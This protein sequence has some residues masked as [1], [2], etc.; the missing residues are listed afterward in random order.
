[1]TVL[2][3]IL[4]STVKHLKWHRH[5]RIKTMTDQKI[6]DNAPEGAIIFSDVESVYIKWLKPQTGI[7]ENHEG[8]YGILYW[9]EKFKEWDNVGA[10]YAAKLLCSS[11]S[12]ADIKE[13]VELRKANAEVEKERDVLTAFIIKRMPPIKAM[14]S[15]YE[16]C[17]IIADEVDSILEAHNLEQQVKGV[18][19]YADN[20]KVLPWLAVDGVDARTAIVLA[21]LSAKALKEGKQ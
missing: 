13:L 21:Q 19:A 11:R 5:M 8:K 12:L 18:N 9:D 6:L 3:L 4:T 20:L 7:F 16:I 17:K 10:I 15:I 14:S 2:S 1:M